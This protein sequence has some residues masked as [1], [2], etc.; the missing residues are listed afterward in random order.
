MRTGWAWLTCVAILS[1]C[2]SG[3]DASPSTPPG[4]AGGVAS[5]LCRTHRVQIQADEQTLKLDQSSGDTAA[6]AALRTKI[7]ADLA[8]AQAIPGCNVDDLALR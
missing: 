2:G 1:G 3:S 4:P 6:A 5:V 8:T 7:E